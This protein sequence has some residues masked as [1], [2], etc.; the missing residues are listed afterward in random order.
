MTTFPTDGVKKPEWV[1][2]S[3]NRCRDTIICELEFNLR[4]LLKKIFTTEARRH[5]EDL[6]IVNSACGAVNKVELC[7]SVVNCF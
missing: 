7:T 5:R 6:C 3:K 4:G 2:V 1:S